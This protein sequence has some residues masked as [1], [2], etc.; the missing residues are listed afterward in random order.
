MGIFGPPNIEKMKAK[1]NVKGLIKALSYRKNIDERKAAAE[2]LGTIGDSRAVE[3]LITALKDEDRRVHG[4]AAKALGETGD[5]RA[6]EP[7]IPDLKHKDWYVRKVTASALGQLGWKPDNGEIRAWYWIAQSNWEEAVALGSPVVEPLIVALKDS[8]WLIRE[9]A[10]EA[11]RQLGWK[12]DRGENGAWYW[13]A[14]RNWDMASNHGSAAVEPLITVLGLRGDI[15]RGAVKALGKIGDPRAVEPLIAAFNA[16]RMDDRVEAAKA[17]G[18]IDDP[19]VVDFF[20]AVLDN[21][22]STDRW[23]AAKGLGEIGHTRAVEPLIA[24]LKDE[25]WEVRK[26]AADGLGRIG[27]SRAVK[28]LL[29]V[30]GRKG[31][32]WDVSH[33]AH[34][35]LIRIG[36][37]DLK[38]LVAALMDDDEWVRERAGGVLWSIGETAVEPLIT[39]LN[40][41]NKGVRE[42]SA[43]SLGHIHD[44]RA[45]EPLIAALK[46]ENWEVRRAAFGS[47]GRIRDARA[48][49]PLI[50]IL[51]DKESN[52]KKKAEEGLEQ[53]TGQKF[54][55]NHKKWQQWWDENKEKVLK[56]K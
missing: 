25:N 30:R 3:T 4:A 6:V 32:E 38:P 19:R 24:A 28:P 44:S 1:K 18:R 2:A 46:D 12:P 56:D 7:L 5:L 52:D 51:E 16:N 40:S 23:S 36:K 42:V 33:A 43:R 10:A 53:I 50:T 37:T 9:G 35:A 29:K 39:A 41:E 54:G 21:N 48:V 55:Q 8:Y 17:L 20:I 31:S 14:K 49:E 15:Y 13:I 34:M 27:D 45:V 26:A 47:L 11:L 22:N